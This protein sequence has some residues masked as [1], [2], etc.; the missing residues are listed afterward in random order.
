MS[1]SVENEGRFT[2]SWILPSGATQPPTFIL[3][4]S[5]TS[6]L[7]LSE[8]TNGDSGNYQCHVDYVGLA[9]KPER[10]AVFNITLSTLT[11]TGVL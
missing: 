8:F 3:D 11:L 4:S 1:C 10:G 2:W 9:T 7:E 5:R 6:V